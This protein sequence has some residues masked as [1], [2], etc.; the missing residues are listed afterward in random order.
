M[1]NVNNVASSE[2]LVKD[3]YGRV[4]DDWAAL[5]AEQLLQVN[6]DI[7]T[8]SQAVLGASPEIRALRE[9]VHPRHPRAGA[10]TGRLRR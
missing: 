4:K 1:K 8:A 2:A 5:A 7:Q 3:A 6:L 9:R 10:D